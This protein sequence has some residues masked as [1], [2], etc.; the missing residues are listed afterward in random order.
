MKHQAV[1]FDLFGTLIENFAMEPYRACL[2]DM[3]RILG[4]PGEDFARVWVD[5]YGE[6]T[7]GH[8]PTLALSVRLLC[9]GLGCD[10]EGAAVE[11]AVERRMVLTRAQIVPRP[12]VVP[13]LEELRRRGCRVGL[14]SDCSPDIPEVWPGTPFAPLVDVA[15]FSCS[16]G[17]RKPDPRIFLL[18][19]ERLGASPEA[20]LFVGDGGSDELAGA[21]AVG[22][23]PVL[24]R[25]PHDVSSDWHR[26]D[27]EA[28][29]GARV[30]AVSGVLALLETDE[31]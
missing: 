28:W 21:A 23:Q 27:P 26:V 5:T 3:A 20:C 8:H 29:T 2:Y 14:V 19:C 13:T 15:I 4:A 17:L 7:L 12:D 30:D 16:V 31:E 25:A 22:M 11:R 1:V 24:I 18:A 9:Q 6:R 10:V